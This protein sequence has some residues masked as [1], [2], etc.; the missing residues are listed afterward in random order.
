[1]LGEILIEL[2]LPEYP[3]G[4][5]S[6]LEQTYVKTQPPFST[7]ILQ[8]NNECYCLPETFLVSEGISRVPEGI[9][10]VPE[11]ISRVPEGI[12]LVPEGISR[13]PSGIKGVLHEH[14]FAVVC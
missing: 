9:S 13:V 7:L 6:F 12:S 4:G 1:M 5:V 2:P 8:I 10:H 3:G 14:R 11:G